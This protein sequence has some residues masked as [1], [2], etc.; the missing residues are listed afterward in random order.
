[1]TDGWSSAAG[2]GR[3]TRF[4]DRL[5]GL[6]PRDRGRHAPQGPVGA[7]L[8]DEGAFA[9]RRPRPTEDVLSG[10]GSCFRVESVWI[11]GAQHILELPIEREPPPQGAVLTWVRWR[12]G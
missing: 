11:R 9:C 2:P 8:R 10:F 7:W 4:R 3:P 1:M 12:V 6:R 5:K